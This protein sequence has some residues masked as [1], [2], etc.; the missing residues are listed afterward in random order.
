[1]KMRK[2]LKRKKVNETREGVSNTNLKRHQKI[3]RALWRKKKRTPK[4]D[5]R[6][7]FH[8]YKVNY[9]KGIVDNPYEYIL[10]LEKDFGNKKLD[11]L[12]SL[13]TRFKKTNIKWD[14]FSRITAKKEAELKPL[15][16]S[17]TPPKEFYTLL[18]PQEEKQPSKDN[19]EISESGIKIDE[20][21]TTIGTLTTEQTHEFWELCDNI[22]FKHREKSDFISSFQPKNKFLL[23]YKNRGKLTLYDLCS[24][25]ANSSLYE[26]QDREIMLNKILTHFGI[27]KE[28]YERSYI[29]DFELKH[30]GKRK[31]IYKSLHEF[32]AKHK[33]L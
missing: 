15:F 12:D 28:L 29:R 13:F 16:N 6:W 31:K 24:F 14:S 4:E 1:M 8:W 17:A 11:T 22:V 33:L 21:K 30:S 7:L 20:Q 9:Y 5:V 23:G 26:S 3:C 27:D 10:L 25:L 18:L 32:F 19:S 2:L